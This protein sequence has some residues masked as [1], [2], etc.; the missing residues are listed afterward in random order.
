M[1]IIYIFVYYFI[2][3]CDIYYDDNNVY[4]IYLFLI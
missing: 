2:V 4:I 3:H 1:N